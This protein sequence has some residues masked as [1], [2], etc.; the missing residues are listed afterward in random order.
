MTGLV[1]NCT[2]QDISSGACITPTGEGL[3]STFN[4]PEGGTGKYCIILASLI[5]LFRLSAYV[6]LRF[7]VH[8]L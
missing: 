4:I 3:L 1:F 8:Y 5:I 6:A 2:P 7:K